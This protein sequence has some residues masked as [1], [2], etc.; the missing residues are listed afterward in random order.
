MS[1]R[2]K[3]LATFRNPL[4]IVPPLVIVLGVGWHQYTYAGRALSLPTA[5]INLLPNSDFSAFGVDGLPIGWQSTASS[6]LR[7]TATR[8]KGYARGSSL[9][10]TVSDYHAGDVRLATPEVA[11]NQHTTYLFK[12][13]YNASMP[14]ALL[15]RIYS[16]NG[17]ST[18]QLV[19][20][21]GA[22]DSWSTVSDAF[23]AAPGIVAVQF[24]F[25]LYANGSLTINN[26]YLEPQPD[27]YVDPA[28]DGSN[29][30][31][32]G[33]LASGS[34]DAPADWSTYH[35]GNSTAAFSY[36]QATSG[37]YVQT[38]VSGYT[39]GQAKW[40]YSPEPVT[41]GSYYGLSL[42]YQS[43]VSVPVIAEYRLKGGHVEDQT[44]LL[45]P[46]ADS[47]TTATCEFQVPPE[48]TNLFISLPL[49]SNG[50]VASRDYSLTNVTK[51]GPIRWSQ[52]LVSLTFDDGWQATYDSAMPVLQ[53]YG[54]TGTFY[55]NP[56]TIETP[57]FM[58]ASELDTLA[59]SKNEIGSNGYD[60]DDLTAINNTELD[61]QL[62]EGRDYLRA[63]GFQVN[64]LATPYGL[65]DAEVQWYARQYYATVRGTAAGINT[66]QNLDPYNLKVLYVTDETTPQT[67]RTALQTTKAENG[68]LILVYHRITD[69]TSLSYGS[70][71]VE[72]VTTTA[73]AFKTQT[74]LIHDSDI[75]VLPVAAAYA[76]LTNS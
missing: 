18:L 46:P 61:Y 66:K 67:I 37:P 11:V 74:R 7:Y 8:T 36:I 40:Q 23:R 57:N 15:E 12:S 17:S 71:N 65:S 29:V 13:Y 50:V 9:K 49:E 33:K 69:D 10:L 2:H 72:H 53:Q 1:T 76:A 54:Y 26:P 41:P 20:T 43:S 34:Y 68:W 51:P 32:N 27:A 48:A 73:S 16:A 4:V 63:A 59:H 3:L 42:S 24:V 60:H 75:K 62:R 55:V 14:F 21:Y 25:R 58:T 6:T 44:V 30:L 19:Q 31:P 35:I 22:N 70:L 56:S 39:S 38:V 64:D 47:W 52:P 5:N 28:P 45:L